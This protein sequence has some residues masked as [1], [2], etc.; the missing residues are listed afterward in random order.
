MRHDDLGGQQVGV[1]DVVDGLACRFDAKLIGIDV[2]GCQ[3]RVGDA[4]EQRVVEGYDGQ[5]FRDAQA[6]LAAELFQYYRK[7]VIADQNRCRAVRSGK[8][9]FQGGFIGIIQG[10][11]LHAVPFARGD[12]VLEQRH[13]MAAFPLG[14]KQHGIADPKIG[15]AAVSHLVEIVGGFLARQCIV[16]VDIDG[17]VGRLRCLAHDN[18]KQTLAAQIGSHRTIFFGVEQDESIGLCVGHHALDGIQHFGI[19]LT[20]DDGVYITAL[21]AE[22]PDAPDDLQMKGIWLQQLRGSYYMYGHHRQFAI[23]HHW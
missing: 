7:N 20:G 16:V 21:V 19:V 4:G 9:C 12:A 15:D 3:R 8:Q 10:I 14:R 11:D 22:L 2:H 17:L 1:F 18:V 5:I 6:Q 13:L 23:A